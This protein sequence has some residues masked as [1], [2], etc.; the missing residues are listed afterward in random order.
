[1]GLLVFAIGCGGGGA[2]SPD[3]AFKDYQAAMK[4][5]DGD[6]V[7]N[8]T[9]KEGR[10]HIDEAAKMMKAQVNEGLKQLD[11][12]TGEQKKI[13]EKLMD[14]QI[15][16]MFGMTVGEITKMDGK[17]LLTFMLK[18]AEKMG[19]GDEINEITGATLQDLKVEGDKA[20]A[21][22]KTAKK[23]EPISF[24]KEEGSWKVTPPK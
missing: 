18:N 8:L 13:A 20:T 24:V 11:K 7:W 15:S 21:K 16:K 2:S 23:T 1:M 22:V 3:A 10:G 17:G 19:K 12:L 5:K 6:K 14:E 4:A 9:S